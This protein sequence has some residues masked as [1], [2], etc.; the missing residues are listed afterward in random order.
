MSRRLGPAAITLIVVDAVLIGL[1]IVLMVTAPR[2]ADN[3]GPGSTQA[4]V[5]ES[6]T[7][8][9]SPGASAEPGS[10]QVVTVPQGALELAEFASPSGNI[11]CTIGSDSAACQIS[12][13]AYQAPGGGCEGNELFGH[14]VEVAADG[15]SFPCPD[16]GIPG[17]PAADRT[18]LEYGQTSA[19]GDF[20]CT[21]SE[22]GMR[23]TNIRTG[24][25][26]TVARA[27]ANRF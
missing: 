24:A 6:G 18:V 10:T 13:M 26:F 16:G 22:S 14:V 27:A 12:E 8:P 21:S 19:L 1:L 15:S 5:G 17:A 7:D 25:G 9:G 11:W 23:C 2:S 4:S 20:M 3:D